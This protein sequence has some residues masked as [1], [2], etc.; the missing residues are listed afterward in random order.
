MF[1]ENLIELLSDFLLELRIDKGLT[2]NK[3]AFNFNKFSGEEFF[4]DQRYSGRSEISRI[5]NGE[6]ARQN[7][8]F[9]TPTMIEN[10][11]KE[12]NLSKNE[13]KY[14][15]DEILYKFCNYIF[16]KCAYNHY[17]S[18][19]IEKV[20]EEI[21]KL[22]HFNSKFTIMYSAYD[23]D[24]FKSFKKL[25]YSNFSEEAANIF[26]ETAVLT[27]KII[28]EGFIEKFCN[29]FYDNDFPMYKLEDELIKWLNT[30]IIR[31][32]NNTMID[33]FQ[34]DELFR[35]GYQVRDIEVLLYNLGNKYEEENVN[36]SIYTD[37]KSDH[38]SNFYKE[39]MNNY[40]EIENKLAET[41]QKYLKIEYLMEY[42]S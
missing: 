26:D 23:Y 22:M 4:P 33:K 30:D 2:Q 37:I 15:N 16:Y 24:A 1:T 19:E 27:W 31:F 11:S 13:V 17:S 36:L 28:D 20:H 42:H 8:A 3:L 25:D 21:I 29:Y 32:I 12:F 10:Y 40:K 6:K 5:E 7:K 41:Q 35:I 18:P 14:G 39:I 38:E 9:L 34:K